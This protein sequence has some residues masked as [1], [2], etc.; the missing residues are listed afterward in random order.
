M[1]GTPSQGPR[2]ERG[3][4]LVETAL[5]MLIVL[6]LLAGLVDFGI[7]FGYRVALANAARAGARYGSRYPTVQPVIRLATVESLLGT[8]VLDASYV[9]Y[10][11]TTGET[12]TDP[13]LHIDIACEDAGAVI[14]CGDTTNPPNLRGKQI[15]VTV[16]YDYQPLFGGLLGI[17]DV[18]ISAVAVMY[19]LGPD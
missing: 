1:R 6:V 9:E 5:T 14:S 10:D 4:A 2:R 7:A 17:G 8:L 12:T 11:E 18:P 13:R 16:G 15:R 3:Q 19:I